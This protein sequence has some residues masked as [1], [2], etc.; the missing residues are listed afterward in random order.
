MCGLPRNELQIFKTM[1][2]CWI[3]EC[4]FA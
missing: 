3:M 2:N 4:S 1:F